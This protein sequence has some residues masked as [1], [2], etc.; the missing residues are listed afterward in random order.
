VSESIVLP[1]GSF[2]FKVRSR[3]G[4]EVEHSIDVLFL[5]LTCE[6]CEDA[7]QLPTTGENGAYRATTAFLV[8]LASRL[9]AAGVSGCT[10]SIA[11][12]LW[13]VSVRELEL[14]KKNT[15]ETPNSPTGSE[16][17]PEVSTSEPPSDY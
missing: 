13:N 17:P 1:D 6:E 2:R 14:L 9:E 15:S 16:S 11:Y 8:D 7:H 10:A 5:R 4:A 3:D 12:Q